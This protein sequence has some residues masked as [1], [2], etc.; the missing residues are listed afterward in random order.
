MVS[1][2]TEH[3]SVSIAKQVVLHDVS[4]ELTG[5]ALV[6]I[7]GPNG[8]GKSSF[9]RALLGLLPSRGRIAIDGRPLID[10][11]RADLSRKLAYLPQMQ[12][13]HWPLRVDRTVALGRLP[14]LAPL[15]R[16]S[17][18]DEAAVE[19]AMMLADVRHLADRSVMELSG[20]ERARVLLARA[21]AVE[22]AVIMVDEPLASLDPAHQLQ[23]MAILRDQANAG[24]LVLAVLHDLNIAARTCNRVCVLDRGRCVADGSPA[25]VLSADLLAA[26]YGVE[27]LIGDGDQPYIVPTRAVR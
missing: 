6:G 21:L 16:L 4:V 25:D 14:H 17:E 9:L 15:S 7:L 24:A 13:V 19:R 20:G 18:N 12:T 11:P 5:G 27:A 3:L 1:I 22:A 26:V 23:T 8:A 2:V 10:I